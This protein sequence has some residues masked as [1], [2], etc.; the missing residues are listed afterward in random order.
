M[1]IFTYSTFTL[2]L[3]TII[4]PRWLE[5][6]GVDPDGGNGAVE[7]ALVVVCVIVCVLLIVREIL[8][9]ARRHEASG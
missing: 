6:V 3:L 9:L 8:R 4:Y 5:L 7:T 2:A 1:R